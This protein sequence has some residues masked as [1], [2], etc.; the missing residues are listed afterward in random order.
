MIDSH[1][2]D[3]LA[4]SFCFLDIAQELT[5]GIRSYIF[6]TEFWDQIDNSLDAIFENYEKTVPF[7]ESIESVFFEIPDEISVYSK[8]VNDE[9]QYDT[10]HYNG[11][12][13]GF[14]RAF[15]NIDI[16]NFVDGQE[17]IF[18]KI[19]NTKSPAIN[20]ILFAFYLNH[21]CRVDVTDSFTKNRVFKKK[22]RKYG[23][24]T[25]ITLK[26][27]NY[28]IEGFRLPKAYY[29]ALKITVLNLKI[30]KFNYTLELEKIDY[31]L[32]NNREVILEYLDNLIKEKTGGIYDNTIKFY[33]V[34]DFSQNLVK[35]LKLLSRSNLYS[36]I[37]EFSELMIYHDKLKKLESDDKLDFNTSEISPFQCILNERA[38]NAFNFGLITE[39]KFKKVKSK[40]K[41]SKNGQFS[42]VRDHIKNLYYIK[43]S[44]SQPAIRGYIWSELNRKFYENEI[45]PALQN[46]DVIEI[47]FNSGLYFDY[48][49]EYLKETA[50]NA[51]LSSD[52]QNISESGQHLAR[53]FKMYDFA[54]GSS[55][56]VKGMLLDARANEDYVEFTK[57]SL[58]N[59]TSPKSALEEIIS[60]QY[61]LKNSLEF[62][63][64][65]YLSLAYW[66]RQKKLIQLFQD[67]I[68]SFLD[69]YIIKKGLHLLPITFLK[70]YLDENFIA[71]NFEDL[72]KRWI[73]ENY[74]ANVKF[75]YRKDE[76][77][78]E[79]KNFSLDSAQYESYQDIYRDRFDLLK[80][81]IRNI[82]YDFVHVPRI[83]LPH[84][85][86]DFIELDL[87][88]SLK[89]V[90]QKFIVDNDLNI[91]DDRWISEKHFYFKVKEILPD[92][93]VIRH[94]KPSW[95][96]NQHFDIYIPSKGIALEYNGKQ[97]YEPI[98][99]FGGQEDFEH[100]KKLDAKKLQKATENDTTVIIHKYS[101]DIEKT[102]DQLKKHLRES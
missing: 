75:P 77:I 11:T 15:N 82:K 23:S 70:K 58:L 65:L 20:R 10:S 30:I 12:K 47:N 59:T 67:E 96:G 44:E 92:V 53:L 57:W 63:G 46:E 35:S 5:S 17:A 88:S 51:Y 28:H 61:H 76:L 68:I 100:R 36:S 73:E 50:L 74:G 52:K 14:E 102:L 8:I 101:D 25:L 49:R 1:L 38:I 45:K 64:E 83:N 72:R 42:K 40:L 31:N 86:A 4:D 89:D 62:S 18:K 78:Q 79:I 41:K 3:A 95:L 24:T 66:Q 27:Y 87:V 6:L 43:S 33:K 94:A 90:L 56:L 91:G 80:N 85:V 69:N 54:F 26:D 34:S 71:S 2:K 9:Y 55:D 81:N 84:S 39:K 32:R 99:Y 19:K 48:S 22:V 7:L 37:E 29:R 21:L 16:S 97:H 93:P 60:V 13:E 98:D